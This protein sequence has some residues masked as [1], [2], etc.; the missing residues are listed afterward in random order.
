M[1]RRLKIESRYSKKIGEKML[2]FRSLLVIFML[3]GGMVSLPSNSASATEVTS[4][5]KYP[6]T[7]YNVNWVVTVKF[8]Q[9]I[10]CSWGNSDPATAKGATCSVPISYSLDWEQNLAAG[11][12]LS[13]PWF[14]SSNYISMLD[15]HLILI[16]RNG[17]KINPSSYFD[18]ISVYGDKGVV[19]TAQ[20][21]VSVENPTDFT[22]SIDAYYD[23]KLVVQ[24]NSVYGTFSV[25][26]R[27]QAA[28]EYKAAAAAAAEAAAKAAAKA[29]A[30]AA[31]AAKA[32]S[33]R[34]AALQAAKKI[35]INCTKG[36]VKKVVTGDPAKCPSGYINSQAAFPTFTAFSECKLYKKDSFFSGAKL[37][38]GGKTLTLPYVGKYYYMYN[39]LTN[40]DLTCAFTKMKAPSYV[41][42][43]LG[44]T[45]AIDGMQ[46]ATWGKVTAIWNY[47]PDSGTNITFTTK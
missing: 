11:V 39:A 9:S 33:A 42:A 26:P 22:I 30:E 20:F 31:A 27:A 1:R 46:T 44:N 41:L 13:T 18:Y 10:T 14:P 2:R 45:R 15:N 19:K 40:T 7:L 21:E 25:T 28:S 43:Q 29:A 8:E 5:L 17:Q 3:L 16:D 6:D 12:K 35:T 24:S 38:D 4:I 37:E 47:H 32:E 34:I 23:K 36:K